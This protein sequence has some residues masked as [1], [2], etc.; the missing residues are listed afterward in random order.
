MLPRERLSQ[1]NRNQ[2]TSAIEQRH[3]VAEEAKD[4]VHDVHKKDAAGCGD[5]AYPEFRCGPNHTGCVQDEHDGCDCEG[6][7]C[8]LDRDSGVGQFQKSG[9]SAKREPLT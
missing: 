6:Y 5:H 9:N 7:A 3:L 4:H 8:C 2:W 1:R